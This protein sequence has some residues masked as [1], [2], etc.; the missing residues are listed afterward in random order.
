[1][2]DDILIQ[3]GERQLKVTKEVADNLEMS[4]VKQAETKEAIEKLAPAIQRLG[5]SADFIEYFLRAIKGE[6]GDQ[7]DK[8]VKGDTPSD[9]EI[10]ELIKPLIP[11][12]VPGKDG[13]TPVKGVDYFDGKDG[14]DGKPGK[15][16]LDG[17]SIVGPQG[18]AG[19]DGKVG[20]AG[21]PDTAA[22]IVAK[23]KSLK[24]KERLSYDDLKDL[25][26]PSPASKSIE[27]YDESG[28]IDGNLERIN[29]AGAG[30]AASSDGRGTI[31]VVITGGSGGTVHTETPSGAI[32]GV[33]AVY[34]VP[35]DITTVFSFAIGGQ[36]IHPE[37]YSTT[38][39]QITLDA[40]LDASLAGMP[41]TIVYQ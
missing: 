30:V 5:G 8:G 7:G 14:K 3:I 41:F 16:G 2:P 34:T 13:Y 36:F 4:L 39:N 26:P 21:S 18:P 24:G 19:R 1:M 32:D 11:E 40:P 9:E 20:P 25:P 15:D 23:L 12:P 35:T 17:E 28:L 6:K 38:G 27:I 10:V 29:F 37:H 33:N 31:T 22:Q